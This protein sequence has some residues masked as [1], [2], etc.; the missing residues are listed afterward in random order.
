MSTP[1]AP[2]SSL[3]APVPATG[4]HLTIED[5]KGAVPANIKNSITQDYVDKLNAVTNDPIMRDHIQRNFVSYTGVM[6]EGKF[7]VEDYL[8][9]VSYVSFK[10]MGMTDKDAYIKTFPD[11][12][13][14]LIA[15][16]VPEKTIS[17]YVSIY[18]KGKLVNLILEQTMTPAWVLNQHLFQEALNV[19][20][21]LMRDA[22]SEKVRTEAANS[23]LTH[24]KRPEAVKGGLTI[25]MGDEEKKGLSALTNALEQLAKGQQQAIATGAMKTIDVAATPLSVSDDVEDI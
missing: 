12:Y 13:T 6:K 3:A 23:L 22:E 16:G 1:T 18:K 14:A 11:R 10:L 2:F 17:S 24:L 25:N 19:Q 21:S 15:Q 4:A 7:K 5:V 8:S 9:A 20:A